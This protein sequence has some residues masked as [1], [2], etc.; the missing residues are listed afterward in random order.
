MFSSEIRLVRDA[1]VASSS[2]KP[3]Y[4]PDGDDYESAK[5]I[6]TIA[7]KYPFLERLGFRPKNDTVYVEFIID[8]SGSISDAQCISETNPAFEDAAVAAVKKWVFNSA[9]RKGT[10]IRSVRVV[11]II[12]KLT[13]PSN[14]KPKQ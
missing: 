2:G 14:G 1:S 11:P 7:P 13:T 12:F 9:K 6:K 5:V 10:S 8:T 3:V 4:E